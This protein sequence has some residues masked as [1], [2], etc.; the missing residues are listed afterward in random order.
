MPLRISSLHGRAGSL[1]Y[2]GAFAVTAGLH[3]EPLV[4][5]FEKENDDYNA[6]MTK[7][8]ADRL[9]EGLAELMHKRARIEWGYGKMKTWTMPT[10]YASAIAVYVPRPAIRRC[11]ITRRSVP[12]SICCARKRIRE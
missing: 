8:L 6:L 11:P 3:I 9:A 12:C 7:A 1:D 10:W 4:E 2:L 5:K